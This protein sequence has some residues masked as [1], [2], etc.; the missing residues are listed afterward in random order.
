MVAVLASRQ[1]G[2]A[3]QGNEAHR[4]AEL[5]MPEQP[6]CTEFVD[7]TMIVAGAWQ[8][9]LVGVTED[10]LTMVVP[11]HPWMRPPSTLSILSV[12]T[13]QLSIICSVVAILLFLFSFDLNI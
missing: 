5:D 8:R 1:C 7:V 3:G 4:H 2:R 13:T 9:L 6:A 12:Y 10:P 11:L